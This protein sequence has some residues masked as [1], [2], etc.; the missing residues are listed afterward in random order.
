MNVMA[1]IGLIQSLGIDT[2]DIAEA[3]ESFEPLPHRIE[4]VREHNGV[5]WVNDSKATNAHAAMAGL[6]AAGDPLVVIAGGVDKNLDLA[7]FSAYLASRRARVVL[8]GDITVRLSAALIKA[9]LK[10]P[11]QP[12]DSLKEAVEL[13]K[14]AA[15]PGGTVVLS[16]ACSSFDMFDSYA[17][18]GNQFRDL[19]NAL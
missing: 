12:A 6:E 16:P 19:V 17:D 2:R 3:L 8:I 4:R 14:K 11:A 7:P 15:T 10:H 5:V 13:A 9:G 1:A 18:R